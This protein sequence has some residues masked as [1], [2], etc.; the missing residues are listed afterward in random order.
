M[1]QHALVVEHPL[2]QHFDFAAAGFTAIDARRDHAGV[3][4]H[5]QIAWIELIQHVGEYT[6]RQCAAGTI[7][8]QQTT[9]AALRR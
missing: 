4:E 5:Q 3:V 1:G 2:H 9:A 6:V 7:E 8:R